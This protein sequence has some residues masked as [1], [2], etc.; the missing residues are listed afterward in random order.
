MSTTLCPPC[1]STHA[2]RELQPRDSC[3]QQPT[4]AL[5]KHLSPSP[6]DTLLPYLQ[7]PPPQVPLGSVCPGACLHT[8]LSVSM[9]R[10]LPQQ[11][12]LEAAADTPRHPQH[13][14][15]G[16]RSKKEQTRD[17]RLPG[18]AL[19]DHLSESHCTG[20]PCPGAGSW[21]CRATS[22]R[23]GQGCLALVTA[24]SSRL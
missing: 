18:G 2:T 20:C 12:L 11:D 10:S 6:R 24:G 23:G 14:T 16:L 19:S 3:C 5:L 13:I 15:A 1:S 21:G 7:L 9:H 17:R 4:A 22:V 8:V